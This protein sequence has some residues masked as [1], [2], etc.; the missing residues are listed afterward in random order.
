MIDAQHAK[1]MEI[2]ELIE[3]IDKETRES[4]PYNVCKNLAQLIVKSKS[5]SVIVKAQASIKELA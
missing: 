1:Y 4:E 2:L 3:L 5:G